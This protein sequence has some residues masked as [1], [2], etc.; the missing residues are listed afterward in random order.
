MIRGPGLN[1][2]LAGPSVCFCF[3]IIRNGPI[4][5]QIGQNEDREKN[6][7]VQKNKVVNFGRP[8][9]HDFKYQ[10]CQH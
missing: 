3:M 6:I 7:F 9:I 8:I 1:G 2:N 4:V 5:A 10:L